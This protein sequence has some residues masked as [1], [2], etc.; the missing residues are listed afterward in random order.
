[1]VEAVGAVPVVSG[2]MPGPPRD[3][4]IQAGLREAVTRVAEELLIDAEP[5]DEEGAGSGDPRDV[6]DDVLEGDVVR[7]TNRFRILEDRG[8][9]PALFA[10]R[11]GAASE[12]VVVVEVQVDVDRVRGR[13][14]EA[15]LLEGARGTEQVVVLIDLE[16]LRAWPAYVRVRDTLRDKVGVE[17]VVPLGFERGRARLEVASA[18]SGPELLDRLLRATPPDLSLQ[19]LEAQGGVLRLQ[20][21]WTP[22]AG[23]AAGSSS[24]PR[25]PAVARN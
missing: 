18:L 3:L 9:R 19:P 13:L 12:Y 17:S 11:P 15:G 10:D 8:E 2:K 25:V 23:D 1:V 21:A 6:L 20:V 4:A 24:A 5:V 14:V 22:P 16:G 7:Y